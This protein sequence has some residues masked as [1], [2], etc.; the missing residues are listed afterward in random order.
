M[1]CLLHDSTDP[2]WNLAAEEYLLEK[3]EEPCF[4]LWRNCESVI[5][6]R[7]QNTY[8]QIN[9]TFV[10]TRGIHVVR[11]L[12]GGGA[13]FHDLGNI[14]FTFIVPGR[15]LKPVPFQ[16]LTAPVLEFL[17]DLGVSA[18]FDGRNDIC[19]H[20]FK[21]SGN[22]QYGRGDNLLHHGTLLFDTDLCTMEEALRVGNVKYRDRG[23]PSIRKRVTNIREHLAV[24]LSAEAFMHKLFEFIREKKSSRAVTLS[25]SDC[26]A[27]DRLADSRYRLWEWNYGNSPAY[28]F[29]KVT[30][31]PAGVLEV[32][33][34]VEEGVIQDARIFG[35][36][37][38]SG[39]IGELESCLRG[40][41][42]DLQELAV[43]LETQPVQD[44]IQGISPRQ[45]AEA[46]V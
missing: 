1:I 23:I 38:G 40:L 19:V 30:K 25:A 42:H 18:A 27:I 28:N 37:F 39:A 4:L 22:A 44:Y 20:G 6:G 14:N 13:V 29:Q 11:R 12:S 5:V 33:L 17:L 24:D 21:I 43:Y 16:E 35:D 15:G 9:R 41:R 36:F 7:N 2:A 3:A 45:L 31:T 10:E 46:L 26:D 34:E 32:Y 8:A